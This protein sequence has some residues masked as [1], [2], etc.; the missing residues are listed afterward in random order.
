LIQIKRHMAS[1][2]RTGP[3][4]P[5]AATGEPHPT[6]STYATIMPAITA[7]VGRNGRAVARAHSARAVRQKSELQRYDRISA[8]VCGQLHV[9]RHAAHT[10][11]APPGV[12]LR[13]SG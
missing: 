11:C 13:Q 10:I 3:P 1:A 6:R 2:P 9:L 12:R 4:W 7:S 8:T 5:T